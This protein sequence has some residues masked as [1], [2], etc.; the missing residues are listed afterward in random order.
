MTVQV[1]VD[2]WERLCCL[3]CRPDA[4]GHRPVGSLH[5]SAEVPITPTRSGIKLA[6]IVGRLT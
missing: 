5:G 2:W 4:P 6:A 1:V 3:D